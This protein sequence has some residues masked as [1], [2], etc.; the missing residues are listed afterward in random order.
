MMSNSTANGPARAHYP[1]GT[2]M[3]AML[4][5]ARLQAND[6]LPTRVVSSAADQVSG[7]DV[8]IEI[9]LLGNA[10][11]DRTATLTVEVNG[12][13]RNDRFRPWASACST[14]SSSAW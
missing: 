9:C 11:K 1:F 10:F 8:R 5:P 2:V 12:H 3:G 14:A 6:G 7:G 4:L 13:D